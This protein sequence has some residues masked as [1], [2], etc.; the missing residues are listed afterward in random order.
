MRRKNPNSV[1][2]FHRFVKIF[3]EHFEQGIQ[4]IGIVDKD[5]NLNEDFGPKRGIAL[6]ADTCAFAAREIATIRTGYVMT[7]ADYHELRT[8]AYEDAG[9]GFLKAIYRSTYRPTS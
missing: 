2:N 1:K 4:S 7:D 5:G 8:H 3:R 9:L 6:G